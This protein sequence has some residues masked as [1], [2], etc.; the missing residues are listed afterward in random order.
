[1]VERAIALDE[2]YALPKALA[3]W[4]YAQR[5]TYMR[6][7]E[8][9]EDRAKA[10]GLAE[11]AAAL[12]SNEP[13]VLTVLAGAY[14]L[15]GRLERALTVIEKALTLDPNSAWGWTRSGFI[16]VFAGRPDT[17]L[18]HFQR[19]QRLSPLD[20]MRY[21]T[22][23]GIG[24][25]Y[26]SK[27]QYEEAAR[28]IEQALREKP[29]AA[30]AYRILAATYAHAGRPEDARRA[31]SKLLDAFPGLTLARAI[32]ATPGTGESLARYARG[33]REAGLPD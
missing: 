24:A 4:C 5:V 3:A 16:H 31:V 10:V 13:L 2:A 1:L 14:S 26:F 12:D 15:V 29:T 19:A 18:A 6:S 32:E 27:A 8:P 22:L 11:Q 20:P 7:P 23:V 30:W 9:S 17:A 21:N 25:V 33:L 28:F